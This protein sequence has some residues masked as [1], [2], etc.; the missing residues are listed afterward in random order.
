MMSQAGPLSSQ[1]SS[2]LF[3]GIF[4]AIIAEATSCFYQIQNIPTPSLNVNYRYMRK[5]AP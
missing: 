1:I 4:I 5:N 2:L 3:G